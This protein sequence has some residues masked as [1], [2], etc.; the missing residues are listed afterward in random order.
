M[1]MEINDSTSHSSDRLE[2]EDFGFYLPAMPSGMLMTFVRRILEGPN[3][4]R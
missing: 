4:Y 3:R 1:H 2:N